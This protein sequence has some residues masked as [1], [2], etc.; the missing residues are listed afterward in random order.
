[1]KKIIQSCMAVLLG[2]LFMAGSVGAQARKTEVWDFGG[3]KEAGDVENHISIA[4]IDA[5]ELLGEGGRF[6]D[7]GE[8]SFGDL[9][10]NVVKNDRMYFE[11]AKG[12]SAGAQGYQAVDFGDGYNSNGI[13]YCN[14]TGGEK[15]RYLLLSNV[16]AGDVVT[17]Y[18]GT[19]NTSSKNIHFLCVDGEQ[20][21]SAPIQQA[22]ASNAGRYS[23]IALKDGSYKIFTDS[24]AG[25]PVYYRVVRTP[26]VTVSGNISSL[27][28][29]NAELKF[30]CRETEQTL[31][32]VISGGRYTAKLASGHT[33]TALLSGVKGFGVAGDS[34]KVDLSA[35]KGGGSVSFN[36]AI[37]ELQMFRVSGVITGIDANYNVSK[38]KV[39]MTPPENSTN[40]PIELETSSNDGVLSYSGE[41]EP[42]V[43]Y[44]LTLSGANDYYLEGV[45]TVEDTRAV[46]LDLVARKKDVYD[47]KGSF[48]GET[49]AI[50]SCITFTNEEDGYVYV[51][52]ITDNNYTASLRSGVYDV[53]AETET[54]KTTNHIIVTDSAV[55][56]DINLVKKDKNIEKIALKKDLYVAGA[57]A[58]K[59]QYKTVQEAVNVACAMNPQSEKERITIHIAPGIYREQIIIGTPYITLKNDNPKQEVKLTWYY[60]IGYL[61]YSAD[62]KGYYDADLAHDKFKKAG[63]ARWGTATRVLPDAK[64]FRAEYITFETSF[65]KYVTDEEIA[66]GVECDGSQPFVRKIDSDVSSKKA[67][68]RAAAICSEAD[69]AEFY[70]CRFLGSQDTLYT[71]GNTHQYFKNCYIEGQTDFIF[72]GGDC[73]Y[74]NCEINWCGYSEGGT[75]GYITA[76]REPIEKGILFYNCLVSANQSFDI[77]AGHFGR[78]WGQDAKVAFINTTLAL[79][80]LIKAEGWTSMSGNTPEKATFREYGTTLAGKAVDTSNRVSGTLLESAEGYTPETYFADWQPFYFGDSKNATKAKAKFKKKPSLSTND[81]INTPYPGHTVTVSYS[82]GKGDEADVSIIEWYREKNGV[83]ELVFSSLGFGSHSYLLTAVDQGAKISVTVTPRLRTGKTGESMSAE[84]KAEVKEG[85]AVVAKSGIGGVRAADKL[86]IFLAGDSTVRDYSEKGMWSAG[87]NRAEGSWGEYIG[88]FFNNGI[89]V[90][91]YANGG[92]STRNFINEGNLAKIGEQIG[93][94]DYLFIQ[95]GHNDANISDSDRAVE[96]G[97]PNSAGIYPIKEGKKGETAAAFISKY[98]EESYTEKSGGTYKWFLKQYIDTAREKGAIPVLVTPVSRQ[99]FTAE[100]TIRPHHDADGAKEMTNSYV[101]AVKQLAKEEGVLLIDGFEITK[102]LYEEAWKQSDDNSLARLLMTD[103]DSTHSSKLGGF[104]SAALFAREIKKAIPELSKALVKPAKV[105][106]LTSEGK[107]V[108]MVDSQSRITCANEYWT[109][110]AQ[111]LID[112][113]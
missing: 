65:S 54:A 76:C 101:E 102:S 3:V 8:I 98:G 67:G 30:V 70:K 53:S 25:K 87:V 41:V 19:S 37:T 80:G 56:K 50:P 74:E 110:Y 111:K 57:K 24:N 28:E 39:V 48:I 31:P 46:T 58:K 9:T 78:P 66:D 72:G 88:S 14:G 2:S 79:D 38:L 107:S 15:R 32:A 100:G 90:Q 13:F 96:L 29:G 22:S 85:H 81:D 61:Y 27:P 97:K 40:M 92:R 106:G 82:L 91:N 112:S 43:H 93:K 99:Y 52:S 83:K 84:L 4:D 86:N 44:A 109:S 49:S 18:A 59:G 89:A 94:G 77:F 113:L 10:I 47:I 6:S 103:G 34:A 35:A 55:Y 26:A 60:G 45:P 51:G 1:M 62:E 95:F 69:F 21:E 17:F 75:G 23:Y 71:L 11:S 36:L 108:F 33:Y 105:Q 64:Y 73:V 12:K 7:A 63:V 5:M 20:D 68:E 104:I 16:K 42:S